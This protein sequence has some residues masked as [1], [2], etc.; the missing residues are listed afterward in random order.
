[1]CGW[2]DWAVWGQCTKTCGNGMRSRTRTLTVQNWNAT[3][4]VGHVRLLD[5][6]SQLDE[7]KL[8]RDL[9]DLEVQNNQLRSRRL[10]E[11]S[12]SFGF[13]LATFAMLGAL[14]QRARSSAEAQY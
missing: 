7:E 8:L 12:V 11:I 6:P 14:V 13:G 9:E 4:M 10:Q 2:S 1:M 5:D 3:G